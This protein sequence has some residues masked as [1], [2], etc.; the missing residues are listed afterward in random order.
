MRGILFPNELNTSRFGYRTCL[1]SR[2]SR[3]LEFVWRTQPIRERVRPEYLEY[4]WSK[5]LSQNG[6]FTSGVLRLQAP[7]AALAAETWHDIIVRFNS[8]NL[9]LFVDGVLL[10]EEWPHG[11]PN[12]FRGQL[13]VGAGYHQGRLQT[14]FRGQID[15]VALWDRALSDAEIAVLSGSPA[16]EKVTRR[17]AG[18]ASILVSTG[19]QYLCGRLHADLS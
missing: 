7:L 8:A 5:R 4:D 10:D 12:D 2:D 16:R 18:F 19:A 3:A 15:H 13:L 14:G 9:E 11:A 1:Q 17:G 6:D